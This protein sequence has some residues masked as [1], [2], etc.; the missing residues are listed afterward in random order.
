MTQRKYLQQKKGE[1]DNKYQT[2]RGFYMDYHIKTMRAVP[3][4]HYAIKDPF[5]Q[6]SNKKKSRAIKIDQKLKKN[7][8]L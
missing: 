3:P 6:T 7:T 8:Y 4:S 5:D 2:K 1:P